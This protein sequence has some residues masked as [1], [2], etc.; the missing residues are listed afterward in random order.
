MVR[1]ELVASLRGTTKLSHVDE[2]EE[3]V[4]VLI[5]GPTEDAVAKAKSMVQ[6]LI[7][8]SS[9]EGEVCSRRLR[10]VGRRQLHVAEES[11]RIR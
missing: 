1:V 10:V 5:R 4:H 8:F 9:A 2:S 3:P 6:M 11:S 7:D